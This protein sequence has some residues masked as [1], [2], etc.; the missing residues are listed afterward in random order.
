MNLKVDRELIW[1]VGAVGILLVASSIAGAILKRRA[2]SEGAR[3][4]VANLNA[5]IRAWW[6]MFFIFALA[7]ATGGVGSVVLFGLTSFLALREFLTLT[8]TRPGDH[9][10]LF[11]VFFVITPVQYVLVG[12]KWYGM[13]SIF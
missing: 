12:L 2:T 7:L 5:R 10:A 8:P 9:R 1:L 11:W 4:T 13:F 3:A 6:I